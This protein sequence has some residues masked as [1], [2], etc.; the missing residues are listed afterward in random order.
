VESRLRN[1]HN[2]LYGDRVTNVRNF[3]LVC[4]GQRILHSACTN[5]RLLPRSS[6]VRW[7]RRNSGLNSDHCTYANSGA[8]EKC[9]QQRQIKRKQQCENPSRGA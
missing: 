9:A 4:L 2:G 7:R 1:R 3:Q 8:R 5:D 6:H